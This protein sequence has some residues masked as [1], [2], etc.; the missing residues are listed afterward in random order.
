MLYVFLVYHHAS[1]EITF[2]ETR[3]T[4]ESGPN[5]REQKVQ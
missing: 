5:S 3:H 4:Q 2:K 1:T